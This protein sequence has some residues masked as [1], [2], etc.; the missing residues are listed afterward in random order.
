M[1]SAASRPAWVDDRLFPYQSRFAEV[2]GAR[3][4][5]VDEGSGPTLLMLHGNP[6]WS[7]LYRDVIAGLRDRFRCIALDYPGFGLSTAG[8]GYGFTAAEHCDVVAGF[9]AEL[10]LRDW[11]PV[12]QDWG[13]PIGLG[14]AVRAPERVQAVA[15]LNSW[16]W[17]LQ[18][19]RIVEVFSRLM[20]GPLGGVAI[21][22]FNAFVNVGIRRETKRVGPL[23]TV[24][25]HYRR[26]FPTAQSRKP[27]HVFPR[28][29]L[30]ARPFLPDV[31]R[32][33]D[34]LRELPALV[35]FSDRD[36]VFG[37]AQAKRFED[38]FPNHER[39]TIENAGHY[40]Q[41]D[42]PQEIAAA[43]ARWHPGAR[44]MAPSY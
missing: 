39:I 36:P 16:A 24:M 5:Y 6:T 28:E 43:I 21:R 3:V 12:V 44:A 33:L 9:V 4:H 10:D 17:P 42:A 7:F 32:E 29:L 30:G 40:L 14:A 19:N 37:E 15:I 18:G 22:R 35:C 27:I 8:P 26:P 34:R 23:R 13:G 1:S 38:A 25:D 11:T 41:E 20:G 2:A 31:E